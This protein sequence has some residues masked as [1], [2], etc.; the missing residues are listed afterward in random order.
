M[1]KYHILI[2]I[3]LFLTFKVYT[4]SDTHLKK[5]AFYYLNYYVG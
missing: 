2:I 1:Y 4:V 3:Y 5:V